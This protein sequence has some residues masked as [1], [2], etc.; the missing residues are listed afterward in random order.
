MTTLDELRRTLEERATT[1]P[2]GHGLVQ[3][4]QVGAA[5]VRHRRRVTRVILGAGLAL[6]VAV[7][8]PVV[9]QQRRAAPTPAIVPDRARLADEM[10]LNIDPAAG[11]R[12]G[13]WGTSA[14][15]QWLEVFVPTSTG[16]DYQAHVAAYPPGHP[17]RKAYPG[18]TV[19][20]TESQGRPARYL[21]GSHLEMLVWRD[22]GGNQ[23]SVERRAFPFPDGPGASS[24]A[25]DSLDRA[26]LQKIAEAVRFEAPRKIRMP[27]RFGPLRDG[28]RFGSMSVQHDEPQ[29]VQ[30]VM[31]MEYPNTRSDNRRQIDIFVTTGR[32]NGEESGLTAVPDI[33]GYRAWYGPYGDNKRRNLLLLQVG[34][35]SLEFITSPGMTRQ[36]IIDLS[37]EAKLIPC[38][39]VDA[40]E[41]PIS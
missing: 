41:P 14:S 32:R 33:N 17:E 9:V 3:A 10:T 13:Q 21:H 22:A 26:T 1:A 12:V 39:Q 23:I 29:R 4:A 25:Q 16:R 20:M 40:W 6:A 35:C 18:Q 38:E 34:Q 27:I 7:G 31:A 24:P 37:T 11:I 5:R 8:T 28:L 30:V 36:Q 19:E 2:D 15:G